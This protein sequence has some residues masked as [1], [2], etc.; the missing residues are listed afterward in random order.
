MT[1]RGA[2]K[3]AQAKS[4][5]RSPGLTGGILNE[6]PPPPLNAN[7]NRKHHVLVACIVAHGLEMQPSGPGNVLV[8]LE[9]AL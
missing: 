7:S 5:S 3:M 4:D 1:G 6:I 2:G 8:G 9:P